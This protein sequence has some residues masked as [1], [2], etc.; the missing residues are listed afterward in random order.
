M[1]CLVL[2]AESIRL[3]FITLMR[4]CGVGKVLVFEGLPFRMEH[5]IKN[6]A[7][8]VINSG[9]ENLCEVIQQGTK[10][11]PP[12]VT[13]IEPRGNRYGA[14]KGTGIHSVI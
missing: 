12:T 1:K 8:R 11:L 10:V 3:Y 5:A 7:D 13:V 4:I 14:N 2:G 6:G 9:T